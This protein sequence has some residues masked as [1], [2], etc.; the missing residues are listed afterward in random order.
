M[1]DPKPHPD[2]IDWNSAIAEM[3][4]E[5][6]TDDEIHQE[7]AKDFGSTI[8]DQQLKRGVF[9]PKEVS[10][11][12][13]KEWEKL[14]DE[15]PWEGPAAVAAAGIGAWGIKKA[16]GSETGQ[17]VIRSIKDRFFSPPTPTPDPFAGPVQ[18]PGT[19][20]NAPAVAQGAPQ[21]VTSQ[22][23][24]SA[25]QIRVAK[26]RAAQA[27]IEGRPVVSGAGPVTQS[28]V[29]ST[30]APAP[31][32]TPAE[33]LTNP[34]PELPSGM[35]AETEVGK[36]PKDMG[37]VERSN[38]S[39]MSKEATAAEKAAV[40]SATPITGAINPEDRIPNYMTGKTKKGGAIEYKNKQGSD[41][42]GKGGWNWY[43]SQMGPK[44]EEEWLRQFGRTNQEYKNVTQAVKEG[45][46]PGAPVVEGRGGKFPR[47]TTVP[48]YIK[49]NAS[50]KGMASLA[51]TAGLLG[52]AGSQKSQEAMERA[53]KAIKDIGISP[54]IFA[55]KGEEI[56][57][58][59][60]AYVSAG[61]PSYQR[62]LL[63]KIESTNDP[64][65]KKL[66]Q[67]ELQKIGYSGGGRGIAPPSAYQR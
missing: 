60:N 67:T 39:K 66:L 9:A 33:M 23:G 20:L 18:T 12:W 55:G 47:E 57:R 52:I 35:T 25:E 26:Q 4:S 28:V 34:K 46:L 56:G 44:A 19:A 27:S 11:I 24:P 1:S 45:R 22:E 64:E 54:D 53:S 29:E 38:V 50:L 6:M 49:G 32:Q 42:I 36:R 5:K 37:L 31:A 61:N 2:S 7:I 43:Q 30:I 48:S 14:T 59:G 40:A 65:Y 58:L 13:P 41:V 15:I 3:R 63:Q 10:T 51:A 21:P 16:V 8:A 62:E 17:K